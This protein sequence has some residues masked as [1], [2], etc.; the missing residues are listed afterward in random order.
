[1]MGMVAGLLYFV[2]V[3]K[4]RKKQVESAV[5]E[6]NEMRKLTP[7]ESNAIRATHLG[8]EGLE[9]IVINKKANWEL[10]PEGLSDIDSNLDI[11]SIH[12][13]T[14]FHSKIEPGLMSETGSHYNGS[15]AGG[16]FHN[17]SQFNF[18]PDGP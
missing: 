13:K 4:G 18:A 3:H 17:F 10:H 15:M 12:D 5:N 16:S 14:N 6:S 9:T 7:D 11:K 8:K 2:V 1:M